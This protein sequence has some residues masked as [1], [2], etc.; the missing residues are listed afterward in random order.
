MRAGDTVNIAS[1][2]ESSGEPN[3]LQVSD[4]IVRILES[5][6]EFLDDYEITPR[7]PLVDVKGMGPMQTYWVTPRD[8]IE[9]C[10]RQFDMNRKLLHKGINPFPMSYFQGPATPEKESGGVLMAGLHPYRANLFTLAEIQQPPI[11]TAMFTFTELCDLNFDLHQIKSDEDIYMAFVTLIEGVVSPDLVDVDPNALRYFVW[12]IC[13]QYNRVKYHCSHHALSVLQF[14]AIMLHRVAASSSSSLCPDTDTDARKPQVALPPKFVFVCLVA[15]LTHDVGH[16]GTTNSLEINRHTYLAVIFDNC[17][18]LEQLS[19]DITFTILRDTRCN[20]WSHWTDKEVYSARA[21]LMKALLDTDMQYHKDLLFNLETVK[22]EPPL[23]S[24]TIRKEARLQ[25]IY[26]TISFMVHAADLS[27]ACRPPRTAQ[28]FSSSLAAEVAHALNPDDD[29]DIAA[30]NI[31]CPKAAAESEAGFFRHVVRPYFAALS[32]QYPDMTRGFIEAIDEN[33][34][35]LLDPE[36]LPTAVLSIA[37][38]KH[39]YI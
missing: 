19:I 37:C 23:A 25:Y 2:M 15:A 4:E 22:T 38:D 26:A 30:K 13:R 36:S 29:P 39:I 10:I 12:N 24:S 1:R 32:D 6:D 17:S 27:N 34:R 8:T 14:L 7:Y 21:A 16:C 28:L 18:P 3:R 35:S 11:V 20:I 33:I 9:R 31:I 5:E